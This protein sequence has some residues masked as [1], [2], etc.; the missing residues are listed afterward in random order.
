MIDRALRRRAQIALAPLVRATPRRV[1]PTAVTAAAVVPGVGAAVAAGAGLPA[2]A[3]A[4]WLANRVLDGLDGAIA[5][6]TGR[7]SD[8]GGYADILL[9]VVVYAAVVLGIAVG[10]DSRAGWVAAAALLA[11]FYVNAISW[12]YLSA[13]LERR[14]AGAAARGDATA[15][16]MPPGL[17]EGAETIVL[18]TVALAVPGWSVAVM[19]VMAGAVLVGVAQRVV[20][21]RRALGPA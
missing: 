16:T 9:D 7:G 17:V 19:W 4:L 3:V 15:V 1:H 20:A 5:R 18:F 10:Q 6:T 11:T 13:L 21:A 14:G 2:L 12:S 8:L